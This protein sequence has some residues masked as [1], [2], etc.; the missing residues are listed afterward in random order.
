MGSVTVYRADRSTGA[1]WTKNEVR[2]GKEEWYR[3]IDWYLSRFGKSGV[4]PMERL[5]LLPKDEG[6]GNGV[7]G[8]R[9]RK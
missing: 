7:K 1:G 3:E 2:R 5:S 9:I 4:G 8:E 6:T